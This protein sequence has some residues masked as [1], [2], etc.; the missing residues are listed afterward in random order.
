[1]QLIHRQDLTELR[2]FA[3]T[4]IWAFPAVFMLLLPW[5]L[6]AGIPLWPLLVSIL[7]AMLHMIW[8]AGI[9]Y[10][11]RLWMSIA[12]VLGWINTRLIL[13]VTF[14]GLIFPIGLCMRLMGKLQYQPHWTDSPSYWPPRQ[15]DL[16]KESLER[17]F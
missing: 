8:P 9:W 5:L 2:A 11:Y 7:L 4:M 1:M 6:D 10:P 15:N 17:P 13:A 14:Y 16:S 3:R 12:G